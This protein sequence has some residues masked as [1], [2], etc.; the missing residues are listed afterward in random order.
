[1]PNYENLMN[2]VERKFLEKSKKLTE[3]QKN[4]LKDVIIKS[5]GNPDEIRKRI[6]EEFGFR[7]VE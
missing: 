7:F 6:E 2:S 1:M 3:K 4:D 5:K